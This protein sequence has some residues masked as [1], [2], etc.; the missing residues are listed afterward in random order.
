MG[1][2]E[3]TSLMSLVRRVQG[4]EVRQRFYE[5]HVLVDIAAVHLDYAQTIH[6]HAS[7]NPG[8]LD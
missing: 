8:H 6:G 4:L 7:P 3:V 1:G 5:F 2:S